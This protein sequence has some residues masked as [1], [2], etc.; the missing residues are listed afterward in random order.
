M[1]IE[2]NPQKEMKPEKFGMG[3]KEY[4]WKFNEKG[5]GPIRLELGLESS[6]SINATLSPMNSD[7]RLSPGKSPLFRPE[8][9]KCK[10]LSKMC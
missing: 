1:Q 3:L 10:H 7:A 2:K 9:D 8:E 5:I 6:K 4:D